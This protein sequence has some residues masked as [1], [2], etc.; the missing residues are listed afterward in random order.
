M[1]Q[2]ELDE[3]TKLCKI[4]DILYISKKERNEEI[5]DWLATVITKPSKI[6]TI[7]NV[8]H[9]YPQKPTVIKTPFYVRSITIDNNEFFVKDI[10][11]A[12]III[13]ANMKEK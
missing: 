11:L 12:Y 1:N 13:R 4:L 6:K 2:C 5:E 9:T 10:A 7:G 8:V 3:L